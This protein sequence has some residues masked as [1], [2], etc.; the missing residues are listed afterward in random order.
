MLKIRALVF[1]VLV[2][3]TVGVYVPQ[4]LLAGN[5]QEVSALVQASGFVLI[6]AGVFLYVVSL[7]SFVS[8]GKGT[9]AIWFTRPFRA[10]IG[11]EPGRL[12]VQGI[13]RYTRN[14]MYL[15]VLSAILGQAGWYGATVLAWYAAG[16]AAAFHIVVLFIEEPHLRKKHG[17]SYE[18]Y[19][20]ATPRWLGFPKSH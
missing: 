2:P 18:D 17:T 10:V 5:G 13:Y 12:V 16:V 15:G 3:A 19:V 1:T 7:I 8:R 6:V 20:A 11:E 14:P 4:A 9:P